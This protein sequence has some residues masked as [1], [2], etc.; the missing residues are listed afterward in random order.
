MNEMY[1]A[2]HAGDKLLDKTTLLLQRN[3]IFNEKF[4]ISPR[5]WEKLPKQNDMP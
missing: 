5:G 3:R 1:S 4:W 2:V